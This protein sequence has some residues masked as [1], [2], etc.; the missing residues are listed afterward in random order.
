MQR[1]PEVLILSTGGTIATRG[2]SPL[3]LHEYPTSG[4]KLDGLQAFRG[5]MPDGVL[6][7]NVCIRTVFA[8]SSRS[9]EVP[10]MILLAELVTAA[11]ADSGVRGVVVTHGTATLEETAYFLDL[12]CATTKCVAVVG[13]LRPPSAISTDAPLNLRNAQT[14]ASVDWLTELGVVVVMNA[15]IHSARSVAKRHTYALG[16]F[17][18]GEYGPLGV[19]DANGEARL[20]FAPIRRK[21]RR[22][23]LPLPDPTNLPRVEITYSYAGADGRAIADA[24]R[25]GAR[26]VVVAGQGS[27]SVTESEWNEMVAARRKGVVVMQVSRTR[28]GNVLRT[29]E[30]NE[31]GVISGSD[32]SP[33]QGRLLCLLGIAAELPEAEIQDLADAG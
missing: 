14:V 5:E 8:K 11:Q 16:A 30:R 27:T 4:T 31:V 21:A 32:L 15:Q 33:Q 2:T 10:D 24:V 12:T 25:S 19:V 7:P 20:R 18:S 3:D 9:I 29:K 22:A 13:S 6:L 23:P 28:S 17:H 26:G 1:E